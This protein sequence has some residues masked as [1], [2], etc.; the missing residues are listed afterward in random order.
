[1]VLWENVRRSGEACLR[2]KTKGRVLGTE[3]HGCLVPT[4]APPLHLLVSLF[5]AAAFLSLSSFFDPSAFSSCSHSSLSI[6]INPQ[7][8]YFIINNV[9]ANKQHINPSHNQLT[10]PFQSTTYIQYT[11]SFST[12]ANRFLHHVI[13]IQTRLGL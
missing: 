4:P 13:C 7:R 8:I 9:Q 2:S 12:L 6:S 10:K 11:L 1:M 5:L 3:L